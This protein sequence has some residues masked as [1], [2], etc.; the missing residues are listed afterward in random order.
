MV[1]P[2][3]FHPISLAPG[4]SGGVTVFRLDLRVTGKF[5]NA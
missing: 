5:L 3:E 1:G 2:P 4:S